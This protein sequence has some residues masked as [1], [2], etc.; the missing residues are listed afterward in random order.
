MIRMVV[1]VLLMILCFKGITQ[2]L[3]TKK[4]QVS[5]CGLDKKF[6]QSCANP[7]KISNC[8]ARYKANTSS[9]V[10]AC[11]RFNL[12][13]EDVVLNNNIGFDDPAYGTAF[14]NCACNVFKYIESVF[15][16][17]V[18]DGSPIEILV[19]QS[20]HW[21]T[22]APPDPNVI[23]VGGPLYSNNSFSAGTPGFY[24][25]NVFDH[26][27]SGNDPD[28]SAIDGQ[29]TFNFNFPLHLCGNPD[30]SSMDFYSV[31]LHEVTHMMGWVSSLQENSS[32]F[33]PE[34]IFAN[35]QYTIYDKYFLYFGNIQTGPLTHV[36]NA[37]NP[38][39]PYI[40][41][42]IPSGALTS[43]MIWMEGSVLHDPLLSPN[44]PVYS[45]SNI[46]TNSSP[47]NTISHFSDCQTCY[48]V[49]S[50]VSPGFMQDYSMGPWFDFGQ[51][52]DKYS[53][54]ELRALIKMGYSLS[55]SFL[56]SSTINPL[57]ANASLIPNHNPFTTKVVYEPT[58][59]YTGPF[60]VSELDLNSYS[61][62]DYTINNCGS[63]SIDLS[64]DNRLKD[65]DGDAL[66]IFPGSLYNIRGCGSGGNN[67]NSLVISSASAGDII[68]YTPRADFIGRAQFGFNLYDGK[69]KGAF[70]FYTI[71]VSGCNACDSNIVVNGDFEE[72]SEVITTTHI[73]NV[74]SMRS[75][76]R[77]SNFNSIYNRIFPDG[78]VFTNEASCVVRNST[79]CI[80]TLTAYGHSYYSFD[81]PSGGPSANASIYGDRYFSM[82]NYTAYFRLC[83]SPVNC[84]R[85]IL[86]FDYNTTKRDSITFAFIDTP[87]PGGGE[88]LVS[89]VVAALSDTTGTWQHISLS[90]NY[91]SSS[92]CGFLI[93]SPMQSMYTPVYIDNIRVY[94][95]LSPTPVFGISVSP[96]STSA[97]PTTPAFLTT[98][99]SNPMC[100]VSY[101]WM[102][103]SYTGSSVIVS[104][105]FP[106]TYTLTVSD[107][108]NTLNDSV[109]VNVITTGTIALNDLKNLNVFP[110]PG[111]GTFF[112]SADLSS[113]TDL[114]LEIEN[115]M[116]QIIYSKTYYRAVGKLTELIDITDKA[117]GIY[118]LIIKANDSFIYKKIVKE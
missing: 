90:V 95:D 4:K 66:R 35:N 45:L 6:I 102:P 70:M 39:T 23:A 107:G 25:G 49:M 72:G 113:T 29:I 62:A 44:D 32:T 94:P 67:H 109:Y 77:N 56:S 75:Y 1:I 97:G 47:P 40:D 106:V 11:G 2:E 110:N 93:A 41:P 100:N 28:S 21:T 5:T 10:L 69:E 16:I 118:F 117:N 92:S 13:F 108:C 114:A 112:L 20:W 104:P 7:T 30:C 99:V 24:G 50:S 53:L 88:L 59:Y 91:C 33:L 60:S 74:N 37:V 71:D 83:S 58:W 43:E 34:S 79:G 15:Y 38:S 3:Q 64:T 18:G 81:T 116:G 73:T 54:Q 82:S 42:S 96:D 76:Y 48:M 9:S 19:N 46:L 98:T 87:I 61:P 80:D 51:T 8:T 55:V 86:E 103:G 52:R 31:M 105:T 36:V 27:T 101:N 65:A 57:F 14:Q 111:K 26:M 115:V 78:Q 12:V 17:P 63:I 84:K 68:T 85:Y 89:P 22:N